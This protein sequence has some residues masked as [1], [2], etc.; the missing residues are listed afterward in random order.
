[1]DSKSDPP[2]SWSTSS[3]PSNMERLSIRTWFISSTFSQIQI[4]KLY[5]ISYTNIFEILLN[6]FKLMISFWCL[7]GA[8][9]IFR[10]FQSLIFL[11]FRGE[12][13]FFVIFVVNIT[14]CLNVITRAFV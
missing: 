10:T 3:F 12:M 4:S 11:K 14:C 2:Q 1:M 5:R 7:Y 13:S 9:Q 8:S 6:I